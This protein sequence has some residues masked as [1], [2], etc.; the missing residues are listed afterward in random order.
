[1]GPALVAVEPKLLLVL[2]TGQD[3][4]HGIAEVKGRKSTALADAKAGTW[5]SRAG[6]GLASGPWG[7]NTLSMTCRT[8]LAIRMSEV[9]SW[10]E[11]M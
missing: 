10:A 9:R 2:V 5:V 3:V 11:L 6:L 4:L 8:P 7:F 1:M